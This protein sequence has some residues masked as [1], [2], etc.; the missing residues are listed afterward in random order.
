MP[1]TGDA[2]VCVLHKNVPSIIAQITAILSDA[3]INIENMV[4]A[5][6]KE[7]AYSLFEVKGNLP[8]DI[9]DKIAAVENVVRVRII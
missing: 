5:S 4:N 3:Q 2:R 7:N 1:H 9:A 6:K 8:A